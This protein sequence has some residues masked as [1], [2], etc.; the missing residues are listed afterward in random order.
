MAESQLALPAGYGHERAYVLAFF[1]WTLVYLDEFLRATIPPDPEASPTA[2]QMK[3]R[4][5][6]EACGITMAGGAL[7]RYDGWFAGIIVGLILVGIVMW[8]RRTPD[9]S[10]GTVAKSL[11]EV[12]VLNALVPVYW[13]IYTYFISGRA[14]DFATGPYSAKAIA[15][16]TT[17][18]GR[19]LIPDSSICSLRRSIF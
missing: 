6:L 18:H 3:P 14:F 19:C 8:W 10:S 1:L 15:L 2:A 16:R 4:R 12:L 5:A 11:V 13:L 7:T 9:W 17:A